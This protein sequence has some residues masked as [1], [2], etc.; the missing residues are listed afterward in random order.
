MPNF[1]NAILGYCKLNIWDIFSPNGVQMD[2]NKIVA[3]LQC[4]ETINLKQLRGFLGLYVNYRQFIHYYASLVKPLTDLLK[5]D[6][7]SWSDSTKTSFVHLKEVIVSAPIL[8]LPNF[9]KPLVLETDA[10]GV[11]IGAI[12][13]QDN[14]PIAYFS[15]KLSSSMQRKSI[16]IRELFVV[17]EAVSKFRHYLIWHK[18]TIRTDHQALKH[19]YQ[20]TIQ[21]LEQ[22]RWLAK[23]LGYDFNIEYK[24]G[25]E[26]TSADALSKS[27]PW[28]CL[29]HT[30]ILFSNYN[31]HNQK[32]LF[33]VEIIK[34]L[35]F[36]KPCDPKFVWKHDL[37]W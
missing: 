23:L 34:L 31:R 25:K 18:F 33:W 24:P 2:P 9:S 12:L 29:P 27:F 11:G 10:S 32:A 4:H 20:Q 26:N 35:Q 22:Q 28:H 14:H 5:N 7:F 3:I 6:C 21:T 16:Y 1:L 36:A 30:A 15:K 19:F 17:I 8:Q 37:L 13:S